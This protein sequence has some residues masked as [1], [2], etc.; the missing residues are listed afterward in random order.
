MYGQAESC[1][2][3]KD[4]KRQDRTK[5]IG[6]VSILER[7]T[8][9]ELA[10]SAWEADVLPL[11]Y[12]R[13]NISINIRYY[14]NFLYKS[15]VLKPKKANYFPNSTL[16]GWTQS[17]YKDDIRPYKGISTYVTYS[18]RQRGGGFSL[19]HSNEY[20]INELTPCVPRF[21]NGSYGHEPH[22]FVSDVYCRIYVPVVMGT[23]F[24]TIPYSNG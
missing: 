23:A 14:T 21:Y 1:A 3:N 10:T 9:I 18:R 13:I 24:R 20:S 4:T 12:T 8:R 19:K 2:E 6:P 17:L 15:Q 22:T 11:N 7:A 5:C 16:Y